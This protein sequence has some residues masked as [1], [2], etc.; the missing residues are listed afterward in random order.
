M[1]SDT[2]EKGLENL[3]EK[4]LLANGWHQRFDA[5]Y[6]KEYAIDEEM[7]K[8]FLEATQGDTVNRSRIFTDELEH[9]SFLVRLRNEITTRGVVDVLRH[10]LAH[11]SYNFTLYYPTPIAGN[12]KAKE[13]FAANRWCVTRQV[14]FSL[15]CFTF[16]FNILLIFL[17]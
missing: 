7:L 14:Y 9:K 17:Q 6:S 2:T 12:P 10:G 11:K 15:I 5:N 13:Q 3:I 1:P 16:I 8:A 4:T